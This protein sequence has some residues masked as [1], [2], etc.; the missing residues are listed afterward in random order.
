MNDTSLNLHRYAAFVTNHARLVLAVVLLLTAFLG[1][2]LSHLRVEVDPDRQLPQEHPYVRAFHSVTRLFGDKNMV[3]VALRPTAGDL[4]DPHFL[5]R[6]REATS[7]ISSLPGS[8]P[9]L[10]QSIASA[11]TRVVIPTEMGFDVSAILPNGEISPESAAA[12]KRKLYFDPSF[13]GTLISRDAATAAIYA[14]FKLTPELPGYVNIL[15]EVRRTLDTLNDGSFTYLISGPV[16]IGA[17]LTTYAAQVFYFF[18]L[19]IAIIGLLHYIAFRTWQAVLFPL[20]TGLLAA[21]W[22][23][24]LMGHLQI[25]IDPMNSMAPILILAIGAGHAVQLLKRYYE[26]LGRPGDN[27]SAIMRSIE[28]IG[29]VMI[30]A[31]AIAAL[32]FMSL[33]TIGTESMRVF[34]LLTAFGIVSVL[35]V[36]MTL[37][38]SLRILLPP[39]RLEDRESGQQLFPFLDKLLQ[40]LGHALS[41]PTVVRGIIVFY[42][43]ILLSSALLASRVIVDTSFTRSFSATDQIRSDDDVLNSSFSGSNSL[44]FTIEGFS[45]GSIMDPTLLRGVDRFERAVEALPGVGKALSIVDDLKTMH[46]AIANPGLD[47]LPNSRELATQYLLLYSMSGENNL[48]TKLSDDH[49]AMKIL[50]MLQEDSTAFA[51]RTIAA[52][53]R[54]ADAYIPSGYTIGIAGSL[55]SNLALTDVVVRGKLLNMLQVAAITILV[56]SVVFRTFLAGLLV[57]VPLLVAVAVNFAV[58]GGLG[59][60]L[61]VG[62][63]AVTA[64]AVGIGADYAVYFLFKVREEYAVDRDLSKAL[65]RALS[66]SGKAIVL[67]STAV[68]LGYSVLCLSGFRLFVQL[69]GLVGLAMITSCLA[70][71]MVLPAVLMSQG[72]S[73]WFSRILGKPAASKE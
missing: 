70:T 66:T 32:S 49:R 3:V 7:A 44:I 39:S 28:Q 38:P 47:Q 30:A 72:Q 11:T 62:T 16:A 33:A 52:A 24:G 58:M 4:F 13:I 40:R 26:E 21:V 48:F 17:A 59:I 14:H 57:S 29:G 5:Q 53:R 9:G 68:G 15:E 18:P 8:V 50:I 1:M 36:E 42:L 27:R 20:G 71:I 61:D 63:S 51:E 54:A 60:R 34:G 64:M 19:A 56:S 31:G 35:I 12:A 22:A 37:I 65:P 2:G 46:R 43:G 45:D 23:L 69:G 67:V 6:I 55:A 25:A 41:N 10:T 73:R